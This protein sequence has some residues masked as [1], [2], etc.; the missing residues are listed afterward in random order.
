MIFSSSKAEID[1]RMFAEMNP[2]HISRLEC[3]QSEDPSRASQFWERI[4][5]L[6]LCGLLI[7]AVLSFGA[8]EDW[9]IFLF[10]VGATVLGLVWIG[11]QLAL[12]QAKILN[13]PLYLPALL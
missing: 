11:K 8:V 7:F 1:I 12:G 6:G 9:S 10:E 5:V 4:L 3:P 2:N 13:N